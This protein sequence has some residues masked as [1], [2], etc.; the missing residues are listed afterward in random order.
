MATELYT[1]IIEEEQ[2]NLALNKMYTSA[3]LH[4]AMEKGISMTVDYQKH[5][6]EI[7]ELNMNNN[8]SEESKE[9]IN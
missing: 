6:D 3:I 1:N 5:L 8:I 4:K 2:R 7:K 9:E